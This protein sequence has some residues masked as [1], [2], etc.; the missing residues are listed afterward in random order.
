M[1][2][3][4]GILKSFDSGTYKATLQLAGSDK[5]DLMGVSVAKNIASA[6]M[7]TGSNL[8]VLFFDEHNAVD[9]V[10]VGVW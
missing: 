10:V 4:K 2:I 8:A 6:V 7:V 3:K 9:A 1:T 5:A